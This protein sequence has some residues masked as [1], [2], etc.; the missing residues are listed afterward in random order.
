MTKDE[1]QANAVDMLIKNKRMIVSYS[2][3]VGKSK[4][5][6]EFI[7]KMKPKRVLLVVAETLHKKNWQDEFKKWKALK[8]FKDI[9][10]ECYASLHKYKDTEWDF[11]CFDE[12]HHL[13][14][15]LKQ[16]IIA[17]MKSEYI[18]C[19]S[20]TFP[21]RKLLPIL[22]SC[23]GAFVTDD[24]TIQ[25]SIANGWLPEPTYYTIPLYLSSN[26]ASETFVEEWGQK[27]LRID[28]TANYQTRWVYKKDKRTFPNIRMTVQ[29]TPYQKY[30]YLCEQYNYWKKQSKIGK[31][32]EYAKNKQMQYGSQRKDFLGS[33]KTP[34]VPKL[35]EKIKDKRYICFCTNIQQ[36]DALGGDYAVHSKKPDS[37]SLV[38]AFNVEFINKLFFVFKGME[39]MNL[40]N[41]EAGIIVQLDG[42]PIRVTQ[43][44]G[45]MYRSE[46]PEIYIFY[47]KNTRDEEFLKMALE[48]IDEKYI[49][50]LN[51]KD[52]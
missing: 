6:I 41:I 10:V 23:F 43:K 42:S 32:K 8:L 51:Y 28:V 21:K 19:L 5:A 38:D 44:T 30:L 13:R 31:N 33:L 1:L 20:A 45:R 2:T 7:K 39:G 50:E 37:D 14:P 40:T 9:T 46:H 27:E 17:T 16:D 48:G 11:I 25:D 26:V 35:I 52:I 15:Q 36:C 22:N 3:G 18:L 4:V 49:K 29:C 12:A 34:L 47:Y 24:V